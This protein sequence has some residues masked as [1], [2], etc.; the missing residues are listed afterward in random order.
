MG[1]ICNR[2]L[3]TYAPLTKCKHILIYAEKMLFKI[4]YVFKRVWPSGRQSRYFNTAKMAIMSS[5][6]TLGEAFSAAM[7]PVRDFLPI[8]FG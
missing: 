6:V 5:V 7:R 4:A 2:L 1:N 3:H 8:L